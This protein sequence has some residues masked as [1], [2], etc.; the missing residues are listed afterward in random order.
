M[1]P[2]GFLFALGGSR[3]GQIKSPPEARNERQL[4]NAYLSHESLDV[5]Q[6]ALRF[7]VGVMTLL[8]EK[9]QRN[10]RDQLERASLSIVLNIA[11]GAGRCT[12]PER[13]RHFIIALGSVYECAATLDVIR[14][15]RLAPAERCTRARGYAVRIAQMLAKLAGPPS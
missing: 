1:P 8:P 10:L 12:Q 4:N 3:E 5:Y 2:E 13:R 6:L 7:H 15:R 9:G 11:E 14:L